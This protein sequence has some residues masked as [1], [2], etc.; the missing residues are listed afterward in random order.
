MRTLGY[1][2]SYLGFLSVPGQR[3]ESPVD[4]LDIGSGTGAFAEA[5]VA[6]NGAPQSLTLLEP[7]TGMLGRAAEAL[8]ERGVTPIPV[9]GTLE[10]PKLTKPAS[11]VLVAHVI[12]HCSDPA[13]AL[14]QTRALTRTGG[15]LHLVV[16]KLHWCNVIIWLQWRHRT[17]EKR[18]IRDLLKQAGFE[19]EREYP[20]PSGPPSRTSFGLIARAI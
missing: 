1:Y 16:S 18:E 13:K 20:F 11:E 17:F 9:N 8:K 19:I 6:V 10:E 15:R 2:E 12:E 7:S 4:V 3:P 14:A 5:W